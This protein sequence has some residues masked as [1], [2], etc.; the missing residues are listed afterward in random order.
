[1]TLEQENK[2]LR[3]ELQ[4]LYGKLGTQGK[5]IHAEDKYRAL[6]TQLYE[7]YNRIE[8]LEKEKRDLRDDFAKSAMQSIITNQ[9]ALLVALKKKDDESSVANWAYK[10]ADAMMKQRDVK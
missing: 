4:V 8:A 7:A 10:F 2:S 1:M 3:E 6:Q 5:K 9:T